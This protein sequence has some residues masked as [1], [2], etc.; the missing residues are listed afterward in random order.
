MADQCARAEGIAVIA[1]QEIG[2]L[3]AFDPVVT[4]VA[5]HR[6]D[7]GTCGDEIV[8]KASKGFGIAN[9]AKKCVG[10]IT[11]KQQ[12]QAASIDEHIAALTTFEVV[13]TKGIGEDVIANAA[14]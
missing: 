9:T 1:L 10:A 8:S 11:T 2:A 14:D 3:S 13:V 5:E 6:V 12:I 7:A 4:G